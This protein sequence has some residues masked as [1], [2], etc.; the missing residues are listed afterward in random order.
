MCYSG[1]WVASAPGASEPSLSCDFNMS[2]VTRTI[3][4]ARCLLAS[5]RRWKSFCS[6]WTSDEPSDATAQHDTSGTQQ[7]TSCA[8]HPLGNDGRMG[9]DGRGEFARTAQ[10]AEEATWLRYTQASSRH[11]KPTMLNGEQ[12]MPVLRA[13]QQ[14]AAVSFRNKSCLRRNYRTG[15]NTLHGC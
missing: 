10:D 11:H 5:I 1:Y 3:V 12:K 4:A 9:N 13:D 6:F 14:W 7:T 8:C 2:T 15:V